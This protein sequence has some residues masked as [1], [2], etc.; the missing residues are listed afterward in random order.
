MMN[1]H[2]GLSVII[3]IIFTLISTFDGCNA[4]RTRFS[5]RLKL[6]SWEQRAPIGR[7]WGVPGVAAHGCKRYSTLLNSDCGFLRTFKSAFRRSGRR[8]FHYVKCS[9]FPRFPGRPF[10][11]LCS[12]N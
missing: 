1:R 3:C 5:R 11:V 9:V 6:P 4:A 10:S 2:M 7:L 8:A 12:T